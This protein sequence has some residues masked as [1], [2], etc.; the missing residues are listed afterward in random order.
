MILFFFFG[1]STQYYIATISSDISRCLYYSATNAKL[2]ARS[3]AVKQK[4]TP[5]VSSH[6]LLNKTGDE[7]LDIFTWKDLSRSFEL[8]NI[9]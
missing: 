8:L 4:C 1:L 5:V 7:P 9:N 6:F 3:S 2:L